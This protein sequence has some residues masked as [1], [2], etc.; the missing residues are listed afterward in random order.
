MFV[1]AWAFKA[2]PYVGGVLLAVAAYVWAYDNGRDDER[3]K[4]QAA[5]AE[6]LE[7]RRQKADWSAANLAEK[8]DALPGH[9]ERETIRVVETQWRDRPVRECLDADLVRSL[10]EARARI[11]QSATSGASN[12]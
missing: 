7:L 10:E 6:L 8:L 9:V 3:A 1:P 5:R 4:W 11:R 2:A 12:N